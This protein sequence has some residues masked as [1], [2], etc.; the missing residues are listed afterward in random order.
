[1]SSNIF[2]NKDEGDSPLYVG[3]NYLKLVSMQM[4]EVRLA[5][6]N[7]LINKADSLFSWLNEL[8][9]FYD[10]IENRTDLPYSEGETDLYKFEMI[11]N[12]MEKVPMKVKNKEKYEFWFEEICKMIERNTSVNIMPGTNIYLQAKYL[13]DKKIILELSRCTRELFKDANSKKLIMPEGMK[14]MKQ[15]TKDEWIDRDPTKE[16]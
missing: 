10:L 16:F 11:N 7:S 12:K 15:L 3:I 4:N 8:R 6:K 14:D 5:Q 2:D 9:V 1:M 13:N